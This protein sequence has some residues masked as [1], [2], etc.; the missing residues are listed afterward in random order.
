[1]MTKKK[2]QQVEAY[3]N[4]WQDDRFYFIAGYTSGG[5]PYGTTWEEMGLK[6]WENE[7]SD[8]EGI[9]CDR[10]YDFLGKSEQDSVN[11]RLRND[12]SL[13]VSNNRCLP[14]RGKQ[15]Y[16]IE[17]VFES[18]PGGPLQYTKDFNSTYR[19]IVRKR[20]N[21]FIR[22]GVLPKRFSPTEMKK[23]SEQSIVL[24]S[25]RL[26]LRKI[27]PDDFDDLAVM[28]RD[29]DVMTAW[30]HT[31]SDEQ[32]RQWIDN[33]TARYQ[34]EI[35]GYFAAIRKDTGEFT[36]Q[37]GLLWNDFGELRVME[38]GYM[39]KRQYWGMGYAT[40]G[41]AALAQYAFTEIGLN[42]IY[43]SIRPENQS[44]IRVAERIGMNVEG[45]FIKQYNGKDMEHLIYSKERCKDIPPIL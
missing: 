29:S 1:M 33:Q 18:C 15:Q 20:E 30:E 5:A 39:L 31:F 6:P 2:E 42:K 23:L 17:K 8:G 13:Y 4:D 34:K 35:V 3:Y 11:D 44:S 38:I 21:A 26:I 25:E 43:A 37:M 10:Y 19:K 7:I 22:E 32:I 36:G 41:A 9:I 40:E 28:L 14:S 12:F 16:L 45:S 24:K 27:T